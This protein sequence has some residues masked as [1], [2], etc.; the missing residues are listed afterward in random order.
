[1]GKKSPEF[2]MNRIIG[3]SQEDEIIFGFGNMKGMGESL[4]DHWKNIGED[5][6]V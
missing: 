6:G 1:M 5:Y 2:V 4:I 3:D